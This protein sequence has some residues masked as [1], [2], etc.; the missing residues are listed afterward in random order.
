MLQ[1][2]VPDMQLTPDPAAKKLIAWGA[3]RDHEVLE[4]AI[5]QVRSG[6]PTQQ[7]IIKAYPMEGAK[8][9]R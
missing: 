9:A 6:D 2:L 3:V 4:K 5:E 8:S 7:P 1:K